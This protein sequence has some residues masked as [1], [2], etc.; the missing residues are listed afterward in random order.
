MADENDTI[1]LDLTERIEERGAHRRRRLIIIALA[2]IVLVG[3]GTVAYFSPLL[4]VD[5]VTVEGTE[6]TDPGQVHD[7]VYE[8][9]SGIPLPQVPIRRISQDAQA[10]FPKAQDI[11]LRW[12]GPRQ[13]TVHVTDRTPV[14][15]VPAG[16]QWIRFDDTG[17]EIDTV[18]DPGDLIRL[19]SANTAQDAVSAALELLTAFDDA[20]LG[21]FT[22]VYAYSPT[23]LRV[24]YA[25]EDGKGIQ[26]RFGDADNAE[27]KLQRAQALAGRAREYVDVSMPDHPVTK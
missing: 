26:I 20:Q 13:I 1:V 4:A 15:A 23:D 24:D 10:Q 6:L 18:D 3:A 27:L 22:A 11:S 5:Q 25:P 16:E 14:L 19:A 12:S 2:L 9:A 7:F 17:A 8:R 21:Q